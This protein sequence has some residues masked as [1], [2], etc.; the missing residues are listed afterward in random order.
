MQEPALPSL[1]ELRSSLPR[2][3]VLIAW[4]VLLAVFWISYQLPSLTMFEDWWEEPEYGH[5]FFVIPFAL[6]LL[7]LRHEIITGKSEPVF[8]PFPEQMGFR[9]VLFWM[10]PS[11]PARLGALGFATVGVLLF[12]VIFSVRRA[13]LA[14]PE[15][16]VPEQDR[17]GNLVRLHETLPET[18]L[19]DLEDQ[20]R[21]LSDLYGKRATVVFFWTGG[22]T[23]EGAREA[24]STLQKLKGDYSHPS[25]KK[26]VR[27]ITVN[28][29]DDP[30]A[31]RVQLSNAWMKADDQFV[32]LS[33]A[34]ETL[35]ATV[36]AGELPRAYLLDE[37]GRIVWLSQGFS[38][39]T[40]RDLR[41]A[42]DA[43]VSLRWSELTTWLYLL[44]AGVYGA[45]YGGLLFQLMQVLVQ[46]GAATEPLEWHLCWWLIPLLLLWVLIRWVSVF[47]VYITLDIFSVL[48]F[49]AAFALFVGGWRY[50]RW[51]WPSTCS[52]RS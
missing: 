36:A 18:E 29:G 1:N 33:D 9:S 6:I 41:Q 42:V 13:D 26:A 40:R 16:A 25:L 48:P 7:L 52:W 50:V 8:G 47:F 14:I 32:V 39:E 24:I 10:F 51:A 2:P 4:L 45:L 37:D 43:V 27:I 34:E 35:L 30:R 15:I 20:R 3:P 49:L 11:A 31:V 46:R 21:P 38:T 12:V 23:P 5:G 22:D 44:L 28:E 19:P 17:A